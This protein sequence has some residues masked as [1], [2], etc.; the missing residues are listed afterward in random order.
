LVW[1][2]DFNGKLF[3]EAGDGVY[4]D[5]LWRSD[6][7]PTST[8]IIRDLNPTATCCTVSEPVTIKSTLFFSND[9]D[10]HNK[11]IWSTNGTSASTHLVANINPNPSSSSY[12]WHL[13]KIK[14]LLFFSATD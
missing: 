12:P 5:A 1:L 6:G 10:S 14:T 4:G 13:T 8:L 3:F 9:D 7:T 11:E 2:T